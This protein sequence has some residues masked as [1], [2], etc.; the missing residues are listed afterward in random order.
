MAIN[1]KVTTDNSEEVERPSK[2][3]EQPLERA[4]DP[5][6]DYPT[7][8]SQDDHVEYGFEEPEVEPL[9]VYMVEPPPV[10]QELRKWTSEQLS[11]DDVARRIAGGNRNRSLL[12]VVNH[13]SNDV[14][15]GPG[16]DVNTGNSGRIEANSS[17]EFKHVQEMW[18]ICSSGNTATL[19]VF[20]EYVVADD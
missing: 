2:A 8:E 18:A 9:P 6:L 14:F 4:V 12:T 20:T 17:Q 13:S 10:E 7:D 5:N 3:D 16:Y 1:K 19:S 15:I 11:V